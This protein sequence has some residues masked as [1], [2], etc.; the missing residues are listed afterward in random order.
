MKL[1]RPVNVSS[2][3][4]NL[5]LK[6]AVGRNKAG[7]IRRSESQAKRRPLSEVFANSSSNNSNTLQNSD[8]G[9]STADGSDIGSTRR[10]T[11]PDSL[12]ARLSPTTLAVHSS[13]R[14]QRRDSQVSFIFKHW[15][16]AAICRAEELVVV[17]KSRLKRTRIFY[18]STDH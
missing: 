7:Q 13:P 2:D 16:M 8:S 15:K 5:T 4:S 11:S 18:V 10:P 12:S 1:D 9:I 6:R 17:A 3:V 14:N